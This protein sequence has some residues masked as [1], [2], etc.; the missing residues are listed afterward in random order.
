MWE[1]VLKKGSSGNYTPGLSSDALIRAWSVFTFDRTKPVFV[2]S[3]FHH[4][5]LARV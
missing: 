2:H 1:E 4:Y 5:Y 3:L